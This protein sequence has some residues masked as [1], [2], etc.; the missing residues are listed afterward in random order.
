MKLNQTIKSQ[1]NDKM[2]SP[3]SIIPAYFIT[4][5]E[6]GTVIET[7]CEINVSTGEVENIE[8][9]NEDPD[10]DLLSQVILYVENGKHHFFELDE[11][12]N[13]FFIKT[14]DL[15]ELIKLFTDIITV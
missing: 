14:D 9:S 2:T 13:R 11:K 10:C 8:Q 1:D 12:G 3:S 4:D 5:W 15:I 6:D 7:S